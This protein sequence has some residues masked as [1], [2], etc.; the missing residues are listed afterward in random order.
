MNGADMRNRKI[1]FLRGFS[2]LLV[3]FHHF[4]IAYRL[5][6]TALSHVF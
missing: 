5:D 3:L 6:D 1:D 2:I 4:N